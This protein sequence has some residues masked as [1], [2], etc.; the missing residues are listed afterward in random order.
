M[1]IDLLPLLGSNL[2]ERLRKN[3]SHGICPSCL[4][5]VS[6]DAERERAPTS[7]LSGR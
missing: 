6:A 1:W 2:R 5:R 7:P 4:A 3:A